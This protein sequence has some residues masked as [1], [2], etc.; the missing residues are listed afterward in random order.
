MFIITLKEIN[1]QDINL[2]L[3]EIKIM[4]NSPYQKLGLK[5]TSSSSKKNFH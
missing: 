2:K 5:L 3:K 1:T 4:K